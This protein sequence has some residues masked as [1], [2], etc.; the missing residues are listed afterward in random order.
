MAPVVLSLIAACSF[1]LRTVLAII[2]GAGTQFEDIL[3]LSPAVLGSVSTISILGIAAGSVAA[4]HVTRLFG[5]WRAVQLSL[6]GTS[7]SLALLLVENIWAVLASVALSGLFAGATGALLPT[8]IRRFLA[9]S[10]RGAGVATMMTLTSVGS[11]CASVLIGWS[12]A[13]WSHWRPATVVLLVLSVV[14]ALMWSLASTVRTPSAEL[15]DAHDDTH[16][17]HTPAPP[18]TALPRWVLYLTAY[19]TLQSAMVFAQIA[20]LVPTLRDWGISSAQTATLFSIMTGMQVI[21]GFGV[22]LMAQRSARPTG[23][24]WAMAGLVSGGTVGLVLGGKAD[25]P[26]G[27]LF[28]V[29]LVVATGHGGLFAIVNYVLSAHSTNA[30][31]TTRNTAFT[32]GLSQL[33]GAAGPLL[34]GVAIDAWGFDISWIVMAVAGLS[35]LVLAGLLVRSLHVNQTLAPSATQPRSSGTT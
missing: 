6:V 35:L 7:A 28:V 33:L 23:M 27:L 19:F 12:V 9:P 20:W 34:F 2:G 3:A 26:F 16:A 25:A 21:G 10:K 18:R 8:I 31:T 4:H 1:N 14:F 17:P 5:L 11:L 32:M 30:A 24:I 29:T 13:A 15:T 22:P